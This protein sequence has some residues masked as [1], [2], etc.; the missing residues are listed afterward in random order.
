MGVLSTH[1]GTPNALED[2]VHT[3]NA[4]LSQRMTTF[5]HTVNVLE[6]FVH[7]VNARLSQGMTSF[8]A[9]GTRC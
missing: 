6:V 1:M 9:H 4:M 2:F 8:C 5:V 3:V 7:T